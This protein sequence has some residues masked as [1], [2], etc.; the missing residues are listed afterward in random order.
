M[1]KTGWSVTRSESKSHIERNPD[2]FAFS[3]FQDVFVNP[4]TFQKAFKIDPASEWEGL[5][6][7]YR[8]S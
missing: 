2:V 5:I 3:L 8:N 4:S 7:M 6:I 1:H